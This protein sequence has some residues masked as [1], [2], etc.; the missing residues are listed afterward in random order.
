MANIN[1]NPVR[2]RETEVILIPVT[3][4]LASDVPSVNTKEIAV[5]KT[6]T[7]LYKITLAQKY[8][9]LLSCISTIESASAADLN[10]QLKSAN[11]DSSKEIEIR[12]VAGATATDLTNGKIHLL[13]SVKNSSI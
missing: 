11:V 7:G 2:A 5:A 4:T 9:K 13:L 6:A 10:V 1:V 3:I 8:S 12:V